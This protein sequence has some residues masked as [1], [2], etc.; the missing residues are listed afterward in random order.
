MT[1]HMGFSCDGIILS[2]LVSLDV[3]RV[4]NAMSGDQN[5]ARVTRTPLRKFSNSDRHG[6]SPLTIVNAS[7][8]FEDPAGY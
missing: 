6:A 2:L 7:K 4:R 1:D 5:A 3:V 8:H